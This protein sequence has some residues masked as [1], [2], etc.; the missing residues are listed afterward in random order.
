M[1]E[2]THNVLFLVDEL[3]PKVVG[4]LQPQMFVHLL[5]QDFTSGFCLEVQKE[6][7]RFT[8]MPAEV[9]SY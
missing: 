1:Q 3:E 6:G 9:Y 7:I 8:K 5:Q 2:D 4:L